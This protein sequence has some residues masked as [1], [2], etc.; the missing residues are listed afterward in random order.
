MK[1]GVRPIEHDMLEESVEEK[2]PEGPGT[3]A[4]QPLDGFFAGAPMSR[5]ETALRY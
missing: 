5:A 4:P 2:R 3:R 1:G